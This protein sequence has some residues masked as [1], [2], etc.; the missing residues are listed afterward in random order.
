M[1]F[2]FYV[3]ILLLCCSTYHARRHTCQ[4]IAV[5]VVSGNRTECPRHI[6]DREPINITC[7]LS[8]ISHVD[9]HAVHIH[10]AR[11]R[12]ILNKTLTF[13]EVE[14]VQI[15]GESSTFPST[16]LCSSAGFSFVQSAVMMTDV[17]IENCS[18]LQNIPDDGTKLIALNFE[19]STVIIE[20]VDIVDTS[21]MGVYARNGNVTITNCKFAGNSEGH[22]KIAF[23]RLEGTYLVKISM[24]MFHS[25]NE[26]G[27]LEIDST[28]KGF[29]GLN[30]SLDKCEFNGS[31]G[32]HVVI[33]IRNAN[34]CVLN[35]TNCTFSESAEAYGVILHT[36]PRNHV[37]AI[38][39]QC[40]FVNNH[41]G[42]RIDGVE[43][44]EVSN[45]SIC[46]NTKTGIA[47]SKHSLEG[48][49][50][51]VI[52]ISNT[53]F[54]NNS[55]A[56]FLNVTLSNNK[57]SQMTNISSCYFTNHQLVASVESSSTVMHIEGNER[58]GGKNL[59]R[60]GYQGNE[61]H[62]ENTYFE[63]TYST[64][65]NCSNL[66][67]KNMD[68][69]VLADLSFQDNRCTGIALV[70]S[71][72]KVLRS[73]NFTRNN[74][75]FGGAMKLESHLVSIKAAVSALKFS[76]MVLNQSAQLI[77]I[78]NTADQYGGGI[79]I[80]KS[81]EDCRKCFFQFD[82]TTTPWR[83]LR[84]DG[85]RAGFG[86]D[87]IFGGCLF[88]CSL[89]S[90][91][92]K[93]RTVDIARG[94]NVAWKFIS[95]VNLTS[96]STFATRPTRVAFCTPDELLQNVVNTSSCT[97]T[98]RAMSAYIGQLFLVFLMVVDDHCSPSTALIKAKLNNTD[99]AHLQEGQ[100]YKKSS[101]MCR[102]F[103]YSIT[104]QTETIVTIELTPAM[105]LNPSYTPT[106]LY[107]K[108]RGCPTA[109][110]NKDGVCICRKVLT[111]NSI[112]CENQNYSIHV[113]ALT[114][115]GEVSP[116]RIAVTKYCT[117]YC[118]RDRDVII[119]NISRESD[120]VCT[121]NRTGV[122]CGSCI[123]NFSLQLG[124][125]DC[126]KCSDSAYKGVCLC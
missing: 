33:G 95:S 45:S 63:R 37:R 21:G 8:N 35:I 30:I 108:L 124:G 66:L 77:I 56:I 49:N 5:C 34:L 57:T 121:Y 69:V 93:T 40:R 11:G 92:G 88:N 74:A 112:Q 85:N 43:H 70:A 81:C 78:N 96:Q 16:I 122:L 113:P 83:A 126:A 3:L 19:G 51:S 79:F 89:E 36:K 54:S 20:N 109:W 102:N 10:L 115:I 123:S 119:Q 17:A 103:T 104:G 118:R 12:H 31:N 64:N 41:G 98:S 107:V 100:L 46:D 47:I 120:S 114:W 62:I 65:G 117:Y 28:E 24:S 60:Q 110:E 61:V 38:L 76:K 90:E 26:S 80:D 94:N 68:N 15:H 25:F 86:G 23:S 91:I 29:N 125:H 116:G 52:I 73:M 106:K 58:Y 87:A 9:C 48:G 72:V 1:H 14:D 71:K 55:R 2:R 67:L 101:K 50:K 111:K 99:T 4:K 97:S 84:F 105:E 42:L 59:Y 82:G 53:H 13:E 32:S 44:I 6:A 18:S 7:G 75:M 39:H 22:G 27:V